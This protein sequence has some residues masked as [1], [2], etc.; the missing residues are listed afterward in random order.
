MKNV[1]FKRIIKLF[2]GKWKFINYRK[3]SKIYPICGWKPVFDKHWMGDMWQI[4]WRGYAI[5]CDMRTN[6]LADMINP[7]RPDRDKI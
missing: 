3:E 7:N 1:I 2:K 6:W 5:S 4:T